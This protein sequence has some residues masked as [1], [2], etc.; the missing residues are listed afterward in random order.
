V[1]VTARLREFAA[2]QHGLVTTADAKRLEINPSALRKRDGKDLERLLRGVYRFT[3][4]RLTQ[5]MVLHAAVLHGG[6]RYQRANALPPPVV[7]S[8]ESALALHGLADHPDEPTITVPPGYRRYG[9]HAGYWCKRERLTGDDVCEVRGIPSVTAEK[10][11]A[12]LEE[13]PGERRGRDWT[14]ALAHIETTVREM[15]SPQPSLVQDRLAEAVGVVRELAVAWRS[16]DDQE[17][18]EAIERAT[19]ALERWQRD[20]QQLGAVN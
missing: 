10:A 14:G 17:M 7:A 5:E 1:S 6:L 16:R 3:S 9:Y 12:Q 13:T 18:T 8:H 4:W 2:G 20:D 15:T 19:N 11:L